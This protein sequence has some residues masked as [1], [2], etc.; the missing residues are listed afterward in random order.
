M[1]RRQID[2]DEIFLDSSNLPAFNV[3]HFE[4]RMEKPIRKI[5]FRLLLAF[6]VLVL[7]VFSVR[8]ADL[9]L[10]R[11]AAFYERSQRNILRQ[12]PIFAE[13]GIIRDRKGVELAWN[14]LAG[15][16]YIES[17]G[18][19]HVVGYIGYPTEEDLAGGKYNPKELIGR[20]GIEKTLNTLLEGGRGIKMEE[21][22]V[23][24]EIV[25]EH[26]LREPTHGSDLD[27]SLD[28]GVQQK[29]AEAMTGL[30]DEGRFVAGAG[31]IM[32]VNTGEILA[33][34][35]IPEYDSNILSAG[36]NRE[37]IN[38]Y[39][40]DKRQVFL[41]RAV[42][43]LY[44]PGSVVK[45][46]M[47]LAALNEGIVDPAKQIYSDG[48][49]RLPNPYRPGEFTVFKD[50][51]AHGWVDL[52]HAIAVSS[53]VYFYAIGGG[54]EDQKGLGITRINRYAKLFGLGQ[55]T[56]L[57]FSTEE[58]GVVPSPEWKAATFPDDPDWRVGNTYHTVIGQ[59][60][61]QATPVQIARAIGAIAT[62][63]KL[64][65]PTIVKSAGAPRVELVPG[66]AERNYQIVREGMRLS[67]EEGTAM[68]LSNPNVKV[69]GKTG[70]AELGV[71][72][73]YVNSWVTGFFPYEK[74]RYVF[75]IVMER[76]HRT[77]L[78]GAPYVM[79]QV[80]DW[81]AVNTPE[82]FTIDA[83]LLTS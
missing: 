44:T 24:G 64:V 68:G 52:R 76:A 12:I 5:S 7:L 1:K 43:G 27:L 50:W 25:S 42:R 32:D 47:A 59:Y 45:P 54:F 41:N 23:G 10:N 77:N 35:S 11:G 15:R 82:Y 78:L 6:F 48:A 9:Q 2:P 14:D 66:G 56:G 13:R 18:F 28:T 3:H 30:V 20:A 73:D 39:L 80:L 62:S 49:L 29:L 60:G 71:S 17:P 72:K 40:T 33:L 8:A 19:S 21:V 63:G 58:T 22:D 83:E 16:R 46:I 65:T 55:P 81:M 36:Q 26:I 74:P 51:K 79:R 38:Q 53:D 69:A 34:A 4:G 70:T 31:V 67:V 61:F 75:A 37:K 57:S